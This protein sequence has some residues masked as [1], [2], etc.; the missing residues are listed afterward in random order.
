MPGLALFGAHGAGLDDGELVAAETRQEV[1]LAD[2]GAQALRDRFQQGI[3]DRMTVVVVDPF[4]L[5]EVEPVQRQRADLA[6]PFQSLL[7][8]LTEVKRLATPVSGSWCASH[9]IFSSVR[10]FSV[11]SS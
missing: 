6:S 3:A 8:S 10:R 7:E 5:V 11:M 4:E 9:W 2:A 1:G